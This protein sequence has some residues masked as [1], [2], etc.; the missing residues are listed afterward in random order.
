MPRPQKLREGSYFRPSPAAERRLGVEAEPHVVNGDDVFKRTCIDFFDFVLERT[1][2]GF[3]SGV[4][5]AP[6]SVQP[7]ECGAVEQGHYGPEHFDARPKMLLDIGSVRQTSACPAKKRLVQ[8]DRPNLFKMAGRPERRPAVMRSGLDEISHAE[9][10][11]Q[12]GDQ[13]LGY[14][15]MDK[16]HGGDH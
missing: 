15:E 4:L 1:W 9:C 7:E 8:F 2:I 12:F 13:V 11:G 3:S 14:A 5:S 6:V 10:A 16:P